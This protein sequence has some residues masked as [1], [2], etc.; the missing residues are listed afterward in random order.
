MKPCTGH[1][2]FH[3][4][5]I[6]ALQVNA[7]NAIDPNFLEQLRLHEEWVK[8]IGKAGEKLV[9]IGAQLGA[10]DLSGKELCEADLPEAW[11]DGANLS[12]TD[13]YAANLASASFVGANLEGAMLRKANL[14]Y[15]KLMGCNMRQVN[16]TRADFYES[17]L[18]KCDL[19]DA[20]LSGAWFRSTNLED[21]IL[22]NARLDRVDFYGTRLVRADLA[23]ITGFDE[24][25][26]DEI[27]VSSDDQE[28]TI[29][30][31][32][33]IREWLKNASLKT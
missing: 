9:A 2:V 8:A 19:T 1:F 10:V 26:G 31:I 24:V 32:E 11:L 3:I 14:D 23:G 22:R 17:N 21:A 33:N 29:S 6:V 13:F 12:G 7:M 20:K 15:A 18:Q 25:F 27:I 30:G 28:I 4:L 5:R 16:A